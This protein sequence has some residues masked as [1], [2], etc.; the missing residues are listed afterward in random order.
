MAPSSFANPYLSLKQVSTAVLFPVDVRAMISNLTTCPR[1]A[2]L[3][4]TSYS[5]WVGGR[6]MLS[7]PFSNSTNN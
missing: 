1:S 5:V 7:F 6:S 2:A 3:K 4:G